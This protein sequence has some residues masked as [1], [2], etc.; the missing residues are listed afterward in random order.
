MFIDVLPPG[1]GLRRGW[2]E[3]ES[4]KCLKYRAEQVR[5]AYVSCAYFVE[6]ALASKG[7]TAS[8]RVRTED[9]RADYA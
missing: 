5:K 1:E 2:M 3:N 7:I 8:V 6:T 9:H 4:S